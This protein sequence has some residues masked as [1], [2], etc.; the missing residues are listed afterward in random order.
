MSRGEQATMKLL[1]VTEYFPP[2]V[3]GGGELSAYHLAKAL[4]RQGHAITILTSTIAGKKDEEVMDGIRV[5]RRIWT[6]KTPS[7]MLDNFARLLFFPRSVRKETLHLARQEK[8]DAIH[9]MNM[10]SMLVAELKEQLGVPITAHINSPLPICPKGDRVRYGKQ[11]T[12]TCNVRYFTPCLLCSSYVGK[13]RNK[14]YLRFNPLFYAAIYLRYKSLKLTLPKFDGFVAIS[15]FM[16]RDF[17]QFVRK[18]IAVLPNIIP[19]SKFGAGKKERAGAAK[20]KILYY[21]ALLESKGL[22]VLL[23]TLRQLPS[24]HECH[25]YGEGPLES[26]L[27]ASGLVSLHKPVLYDKLPAMLQQHD[28]VVL[29]SIWPEP[30]GR[31]VIETMASGLPIVSSSIGGITELIADKKTGLL[32]PPNDAAALAKALQMLMNNPQQRRRIGEAAKVASRSYDEQRI[33][34]TFIQEIKTMIKKQ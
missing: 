17:R 3:F 18:K 14:W 31:V 8:F 16:R 27:E 23:E 25:V 12:V 1:I 33:A 29:P 28:I 9:C 15:D 10:T 22:L 2:A 11:C 24:N 5:L 19:L 4:V 30:F 32:V 6:G 7:R 13:V 21:G 34:K 26:V 20:V